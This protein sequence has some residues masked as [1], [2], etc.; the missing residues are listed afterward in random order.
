MHTD[1]LFIFVDIIN[2]AQDRCDRCKAWMEGSAQC[3]IK[4]YNNGTE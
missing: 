2:A 4:N 3:K 1:E